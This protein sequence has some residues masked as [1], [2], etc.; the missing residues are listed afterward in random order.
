MYIFSSRYRSRLIWLW[1]SAC[2]GIG[3]SPRLLRCGCRPTGSAFP[4]SEDRRSAAPPLGGLDGWRAVSPV[5]RATP[6]Q[7]RLLWL[8]CFPA[9]GT[10]LNWRWIGSKLAAVGADACPQYL[11]PA[12]LRVAA[13]SALRTAFAAVAVSAG[14]SSDSAGVAA[15]LA[16]VRRNTCALEQTITHTRPL[17]FGLVLSRSRM[18]QQPL[19]QAILPYF[20]CFRKS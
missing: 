14:L 5:P 9:F 13:N 11:P 4:S 19:V 15:G 10:S 20:L 2:V 18:S 12:V 6:L 1:A 3:F 17:P 7:P 16:V 8:Q